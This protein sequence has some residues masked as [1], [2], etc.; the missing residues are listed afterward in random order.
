MRLLKVIALSLLGLIAVTTAN[1]NYSPPNH[2]IYVKNVTD[3]RHVVG[4]Y[5]SRLGAAP[6]W[7]YNQLTGPLNA[8]KMVV[9]DPG[10]KGNDCVLQYMV[11]FAV[12]DYITGTV[13]VCQDRGIK[14]QERTAI[15]DR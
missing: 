13:N 10:Q 1:A 4:F 6:N 12:G 5:L 14:V 11:V 7:G 8:T 9:V 15:I 3:K 2:L